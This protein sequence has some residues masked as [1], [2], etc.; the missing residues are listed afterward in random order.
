MIRLIK[1]NLPSLFALD[2]IGRK[3]KNS[4]PLNCLSIICLLHILID[5]NLNFKRYISFG[6]REYLLYRTY[7]SELKLLFSHGNLLLPHSNTLAFTS[8][9]FDI[10]RLCISP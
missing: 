8:N 3:G 6:F 5:V 1:R 4:R 7:I 10:L 2:Y 9:V